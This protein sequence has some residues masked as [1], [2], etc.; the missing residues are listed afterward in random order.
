MDKKLVA[1][2]S[3]FLLFFLSFVSVVFLNKDILLFTR[4]KTAYKPSPSTSIILAW[5]LRTK[6]NK[7]SVITVFIRDE[8]GHPVKDQRVRLE[9]SLGVV[10]ASAEKTDKEGKI[11]FT[12]TSSKP[13]KAVVNAFVNNSL[14]LKQSLSV[15]FE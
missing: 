15:L 4:A 3:I 9:S 12:L 11:T 5:P 8:K 14:K 1:L 10:K 6:I 7:P 2:F 13:G